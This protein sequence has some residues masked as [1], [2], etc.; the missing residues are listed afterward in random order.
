MRAALSDR[1]LL[2][3]WACGTLAMASGQGFGAWVPS[4]FVRDLGMSVSVAG[5]VF[6]GAALFGGIFGGLAGGALA[7]RRRRVRPGGEFDV[8]LVAALVAAVAVFFTLEIGPNLYAAL[9]GFVAT[10]AIYG[11]FPGL[12]SAMLS[13][14]PAHRHGATTGLNTLFLGGIGAATGPFT[15]GLASDKLASL[16]A[17]LYVPVAGLCAAALM[18]AKAAQA[19]QAVKGERQ[20]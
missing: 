3:L 12:L 2:W 4:Y 10:L 18:A 9:G 11:M 15:V 19:A 6:G 7:D 1:R 14:T 8:A 13:F 16:H 5:A 17:A 20:I